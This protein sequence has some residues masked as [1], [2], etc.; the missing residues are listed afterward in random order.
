MFRIEKDS[1]GEKQIPSEALYG[2]HSVRARENFPVNS[3]FPVEWYKA[4]G[5]TKLAC[6]NTYRKFKKAAE[7]RS[8]KELPF[9]IIDD[10]ILNALCTSAREVSEANYFDQFIIPAVQG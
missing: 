8:G 6:Y 2:I 7:S 9:K 5:I 1:L 10:N 4:V 3:Q